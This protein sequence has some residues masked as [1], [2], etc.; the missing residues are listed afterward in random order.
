MENYDR[1]EKV[2]ERER[3]RIEEGD[4]VQVSRLALVL[5][6]ITEV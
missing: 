2:R 5:H 3:M 4:V 1:G 6:F